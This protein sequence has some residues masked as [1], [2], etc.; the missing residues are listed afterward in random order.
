M[1][2]GI[3][4]GK[5]Y[6]ANRNRTK[7]IS[8]FEQNGSRIQR[9]QKPERIDLNQ[10]LLMRRFTL[11]VAFPFRRGTSPFSKIFS[12]VIQRRCSHWQECLRHVSVPF[13]RR[14]WA[15]MFDVTERVRT[16]LYMLDVDNVNS[17]T[18]HPLHFECLLATSA[19]CFF[20][21]NGWKINRIGV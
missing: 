1:V 16:C 10:V 9:F 15:R 8:A 14:C 13:R 17:P 12:C 11:Y 5:F 4:S 21:R 18:S 7:I 3:W 19:T 20:F 6:D 2:S